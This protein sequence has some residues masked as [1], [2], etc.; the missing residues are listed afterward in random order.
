MT[1]FVLFCFVLFCIADGPHLSFF[2]T[3]LGPLPFNNSLQSENR[4]SKSRIEFPAL[5][6]IYQPGFDRIGGA[7]KNNESHQQ[8]L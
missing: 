5:A 8:V 2:L 7:V 3:S 1:A 4:V 6:S